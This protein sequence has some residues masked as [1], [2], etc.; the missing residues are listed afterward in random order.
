MWMLE[1]K[2][3]SSA[4]ATSTLTAEP[5][6]QPLNI[7]FKKINER[8]NHFHVECIH[9]QLRQH[10]AQNLQFAKKFPELQ[11]IKENMAN[12]FSKY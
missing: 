11:Q 2:P 10:N 5:S 7:D 4:R 12:K 1:T 8:T 6:P 3:G 9:A